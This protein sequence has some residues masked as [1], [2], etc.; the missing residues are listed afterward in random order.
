MADLDPQIKVESEEP[1]FPDTQS[2]IDVAEGDEVRS[3]V[4]ENVPMTATV[5]NGNL[6]P[7]A[8]EIA[9]SYNDMAWHKCDCAPSLSPLQRVKIKEKATKD[10]VVTIQWLL[11]KLDSGKNVFSTSIFEDEISMLCHLSP[12]SMLIANLETLIESV[13][14]DIITVGFMGITGS[15]KSSL[16]K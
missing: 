16:I 7:S 13:N 8:L 6:P 1:H 14:D 15:G 4:K 11:P 3:F 10:A 12:F 2:D 9:T 5:P